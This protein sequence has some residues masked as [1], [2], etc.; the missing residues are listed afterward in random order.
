MLLQKPSVTKHFKVA[1]KN[2]DALDDSLDHYTVDCLV[3]SIIPVV[4]GPT[5]SSCLKLQD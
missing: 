3:L 2:L 4:H 1:I 5:A